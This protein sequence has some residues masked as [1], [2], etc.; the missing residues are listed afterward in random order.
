MKPLTLPKIGSPRIV[1]K[2]GRMDQ[3]KFERLALEQLT[4]DQRYQVPFSQKRVDDIVKNFDPLLLA[5]ITVSRRRDGICVI[6]DGQHRDLALIGLGYDSAICEVFDGLTYEQE[7]HIFAERNRRRRTA[8]PLQ[9]FNARVE[10][11]TQPDAT[12]ASIVREAGYAIPRSPNRGPRL[13]TCPMQLTDIYGW[14]KLKVTLFVLGE[15][16]PNETDATLADVTQGVAAFLKNWP[17]VDP[18]ELVRKLSRSHASERGLAA[19]YTDAIARRR[20]S[21]NDFRVWAHFAAVLKEAY[22]AGRRGGRLAD[23]PISIKARSLWR[24]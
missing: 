23:R 4:T 21:R 10:A 17:E 20:H 8:H 19:L 14:G 6:L 1:N 5:P 16:W 11:N 9:T 13:L 18:N 15:L 24:A 22:D 2:N 3:P 12:I 7:A